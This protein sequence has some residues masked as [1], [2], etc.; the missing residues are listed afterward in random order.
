VSAPV[1]L[2]LCFDTSRTSP[3]WFGY[4]FDVVVL[5]NAV[6]IGIGLESPEI[7]LLPL[8]NLELLLKLYTFGFRRFVRS[9]WNW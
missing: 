1:A 9:A 8:Y 5:C 2:H 4:F 3:R 7:V 6:F